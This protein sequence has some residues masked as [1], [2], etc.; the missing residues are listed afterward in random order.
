MIFRGAP[1]KKDTLYIKSNI[2]F[3]FVGN[4]STNL[5]RDHFPASPDL[6]VTDEASL[7]SYLSNYRYVSH[8]SSLSTILASSAKLCILLV[9]LQSL[10]VN[11]AFTCSRRYSFPGAEINKVLTTVVP[12]QGPEWGLG[13]NQTSTSKTMLWTEKCSV[14]LPRLLAPQL[15]GDH[16]PLSRNPDSWILLPQEEAASRCF[17]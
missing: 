10:G 1:V 5:R 2:D 16:I 13:L 7:A 17:I 12:R 15:S 4:T 6:S 9:R 3:L 14:V 11:T 8:L